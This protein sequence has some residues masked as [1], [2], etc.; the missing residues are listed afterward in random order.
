MQKRIGTDRDL[1][2]IIKSLCWEQY[3]GTNTGIQRR[4]K[5]ISEFFPEVMFYIDRIKLIW[6]SKCEH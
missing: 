4:M 2:V 1:K 6:T 3:G 5:G